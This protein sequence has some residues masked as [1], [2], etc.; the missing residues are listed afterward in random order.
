MKRP[1]LVLGIVWALSGLIVGRHLTRGWVPHDEGSLAQSAERVLAGEL[2]HRDFDEPYT[3]GL[4]HLNAV[5]FRLLGTNLV[6]LRLVLLICFLAWIPALYYVAAQ[7]TSP[8]GAG[9]A[10]MLSVVWSVPN[11]S[12]AVPSWYNLFLAVFGIAALLRYLDTRQAR[13][14]FAAGMCGGLSCLVKIVGLYYVAAVLL[15]L[16]FREQCVSAASPG[17]RRQARGPYSWA[18]VVALLGFVALLGALVRS[19]WD[20]ADVAHFVVPGAALAAVLLRSEWTQPRGPS[21]ER[22]GALGRLVAP[23]ALG[24]AVPVAW[25]AAPYILSGSLA[26]LWRGVFVLPTRRLSVATMPLWGLGTTVAALPLVAALATAAR[27]SAPTRRIVAWLVV[28]ALTLLSAAS[29]AGDVYLAVWRSV[30]PLIPLLVLGGALLLGSSARAGGQLAPLR[31]QQVLLVLSVTALCGL[32]QFPFS[33]PIYFCYVAPLV[34]LSALAVCAALGTI[35]PLLTAVVAGFYG[36]FALRAVNPGFIYDMGIRYERD[37]QVALLALDRGGLRVT[38]ADKRQYESLVAAI[39]LHARDGVVYATPDCPEVYFLAGQHNP[40]RTIFDF[41][42]D[43]VGRTG[44]LMRVIEE[45]HVNVV[46]LNRDPSFSRP[47]APA[48]ETWLAAR[49]P[50]AMPI[51]RFDVRWAE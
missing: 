44:R 46:I 17:E 20:A 37:D 49:F 42:D 45:R 1:W 34:V 13:W 16:V 3:G 31:R 38:P 5:A 25:F 43:P 51:G 6:S 12:A 41:F 8:L 24:V 40:T 48:F 26:D 30:R 7:F 28:P 35:P 27:G 14:L 36:L 21:R 11:Y 39:R 33:A 23:F 4:S 19:R 29:F 9:A 47:P 15:F 10:V 50:H 2:P 32:V 22:F 18:L